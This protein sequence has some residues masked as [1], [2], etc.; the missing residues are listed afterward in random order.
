MDLVLSEGIRTEIRDSQ[1]G[2]PRGEWKTPENVS[3]SFASHN[4]LT[5]AAWFYPALGSLNGGSNVV[6]SYVG[7]ETRNGLSVQHLRSY[8]YSPGQTSTAPQQ[9]STMNFYLDARTTLPVSI[10]FNTHSDTDASTNLLV[11]IRFSNYQNTNGAFVPMHIQKYQD[12]SLTLDLNISS[13]AFNSGLQLSNF[14]IN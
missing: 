4:C 5:D 9:L 11:E 6:I 14:T 3:G 13:L 8:R 7:Q 1:T 2:I 10:T 12:G